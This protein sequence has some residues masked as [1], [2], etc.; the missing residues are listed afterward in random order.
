M[1]GLRAWD[2]LD[3]ILILSREIRK[4]AMKEHM[5]ASVGN[6]HKSNINH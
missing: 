4:N 1:S 5:L 3:A 6:C 2:S